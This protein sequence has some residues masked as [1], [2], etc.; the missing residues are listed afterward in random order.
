[1][2]T[3]SNIMGRR[4]MGKTHTFSEGNRKVRLKYQS[5]GDRAVG[6]WV[7]SHGGSCDRFR[8]L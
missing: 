2:I 6:T 5:G 7:E 1:M 3:Q 8:R 4:I